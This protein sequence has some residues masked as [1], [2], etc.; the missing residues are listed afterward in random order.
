MERMGGEMR[1]YLIIW[2]RTSLASVQ[3]VLTHR[4]GAGLFLVGKFIRFGLFI[5]FLQVLQQRL[6]SVGGYGFSEL[7]TFFLMF[8]ILD[9]VGQIFFRGIYWFRNQ[10]VSGEF[11]FALIQPVSA[12]FR[13][14]TQ[15]T[16]VLDVPLMVVVMVVL[17][18]Q[19]LDWW[20]RNGAMGLIALVSGMVIVVAIHIVVAALGVMTTEVDH[21]IMIYRDVAQM[22]RLP[23]DIYTD[24]IRAVLT[25]VVPIGVAFTFPAKALLGLLTWPVVAVSMVGA[26][27]TLWMTLKLW[28]YALKQ[29]ASASS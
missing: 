13:V 16:D 6:T 29:Y 3:G 2:L 23:I 19:P 21:T 10:V 24:W 18:R 28:N 25:F 5:F 11:D 26:M 7:L 4:G 22:A 8:N 1:K 15:H 20:G 9:M 14:L 17:A 27:V 12:L